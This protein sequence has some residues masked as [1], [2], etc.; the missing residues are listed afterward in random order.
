MLFNKKNELYVLPGIQGAGSR[1]PHTSPLTYYLPFRWCPRLQN[2]D[3]AI[4][5]HLP[6][7]A[8]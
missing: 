1:L 3:G 4:I 5:S 7:A 2:R 8:D 6:M